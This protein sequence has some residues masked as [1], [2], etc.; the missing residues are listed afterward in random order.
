MSFSD[1]VHRVLEEIGVDLEKLEAAVEPGYLP[2][3][4]DARI[5]YFLNAAQ[6]GKNRIVDG[7][8]MCVDHEGSSDVLVTEPC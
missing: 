5:G 4:L 1:T 6:Y 3:S 2:A 7:H 8:R